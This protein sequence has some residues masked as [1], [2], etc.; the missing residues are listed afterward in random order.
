MLFFKKRIE[1]FF[2]LSRSGSDQVMQADSSKNEPDSMNNVVYKR[3]DHQVLENVD[4]RGRRKNGKS[5]VRGG[6]TVPPS[7]TESSHQLFEI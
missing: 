7:L 4:L 1:I 5:S 6:G 3:K 2:N